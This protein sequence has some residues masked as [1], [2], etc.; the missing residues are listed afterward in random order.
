[1]KNKTN[2][3][4][5][6]TSAIHHENG[7]LLIS[8]S[9]GSGKTFVM[10]S[11]II[12]LILE[13]KAKVDEILAVTYTRLAAEEMKQ[14]L[15]KALI[16]AINSGKDRE[17]LMT[18]LNDVANA[19]ISTFH[20]FLIRL[21]R[22]SFFAIGIDPLFK[23]ADDTDAETLKKRAIDRL[24][25]DKY[26]DGD[27]NFYYLTRIFRKYRADKNLKDEIFRIYEFASAEAEPNGFLLKMKEVSEEKYKF[28][29]D[30]LLD[31]YKRKLSALCE[32]VENVKENAEKFDLKKY[33]DYAE[34]L[35][36]GM[37]IALSAENTD[38]LCLFADGSLGRMPTISN[39]DE[40]TT[41]IGDKLK[42]I[43]ENLAKLY[44]DIRDTFSKPDL[45]ET[46][47]KSGNA[48]KALCDLTIEFAE[49]YHREKRNENLLDYAD[50]E[51]LSYKLLT[52]NEQVRQEIKNKYKYIFADE[53]QDVNGVQEAILNL[54]GSDNVFMVGDVKQSIYAFRGCNPDI[55][56]AK[57][58]EYEKSS[59]GT[60]LA[61]D[62]NF[63]SSDKILSYVNNIF[64]FVMTKEFGGVDYKSNPMTGG[65]GVFDEDNGVTLH[66]IEGKKQQAAEPEGVYEV[67]KAYE[68]R[69]EDEDFYEGIVTAKIIAEEL[70]K[71]VYDPKSEEFRQVNLSDI[72]VLSRDSSGFTNRLLKELAKLGVP[73]TSEAETKITD[74][75][76]IQILISV[77]E[78]IAFYADDVPLATV[79]KSS[80][81]SLT[82]KDL[83]EIRRPYQKKDKTFSECV[84]AYMES[85]EDETLKN[86]LAAF[87][88]YFEK[89]RL[90]S[91]LMSAG[92]LLTL[93]MEETGL[94]LEILGM[95]LGAIRLERVDKFISASVS[96]GKALSSVEFL[97]RIRSAPDKIKMTAKSGSET[98]RVMSM[99][100]SKGLEFPIVI[101]V[102]AKKQFSSLDINAE[103]SLSRN[104]GIAVKYYDEDT[105]TSR[106]TISRKYFKETAKLNRTK[107]EARVFYVAL[108]RAKTRL[109]I[110]C[111][112]EIEDEPTKY[113]LLTA[114]KFSDFL[115]KKEATVITYDKDDLGKE[116][117]LKKDRILIG[118]GD[119]ELTDKILSNI[120]FVYPFE[121]ECHLQAKSTVTEIAA[122]NRKE[123]LSEEPFTLNS[124][125]TDRGNAYH[126]FMQY[127]DF[128]QKSADNELI[129]LLS[130]NLISDSEQKLIDK[131]SLDKVLNLGVFKEI[132]DCELYRE[133]PFVVPLKA[134]D[135]GEGTSEREL[136]VQGVIDLLAV[137]ENEAIIIDYK[138]SY[139]NSERL[140][141]DYS[142]QLNL[143]ALAVE[144]AL[145]LKVK[146]KLII[147]LLTG[148]TV[149]I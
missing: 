124:S 18:A 49:Y 55:F 103:I 147:N 24:F 61:L 95:P 63:R 139:H 31:I 36:N 68:N 83:A 4:A 120:S 89:V 7:N 130:E 2:L 145:K 11:R 25:D 105:K 42:K 140:K 70:N 13:G 37:K 10:I 117:R 141:A 93:I 43:K 104:D 82:E 101:V 97:N 20:S 51:H 78:L 44:G 60:A 48:V 142:A 133:Q 92:E 91:E 56:S 96:N 115:S 138:T 38:K 26:S 135:I 32:L 12:S 50:L 148:E 23:I 149:E 35:I 100:A 34:T 106:E 33:A 16:D 1:M 125:S 66:I 80:I 30:G 129:R 123:I 107:E 79:L 85:G 110:V 6:Q 45:K 126:K 71:K 119:E 64:S 109:H 99:H 65:D 127:C 59:G 90:L 88:K 58:G 75:P 8:A 54:I 67:I 40:I 116:D 22:S 98:V 9:A 136:L 52:E 144:K 15:V 118:K 131:S 84:N 112:C 81:G 114:G 132:S 28:Y 69:D 137:R 39:K 47:L 111:D 57:Y 122:K 62:K 21:L 27:E 128:S 143:Y 113:R 5:S 41:K 94:D 77:L 17:R 46:Y 53:Y 102:G 19:D 14:K 72:A 87:K 146:K 134:R 3:T 86:K 74:Y 121:Q 29:S 108:T 76:E 73:A